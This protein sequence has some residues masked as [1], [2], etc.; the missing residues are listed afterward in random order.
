MVIERERTAITPMTAV[1]LL[2]DLVSIPSVSGDEAC[3]VSWLCEV[4]ESLGYDATIDGAGNAVGTT[5]QGEREILLLGHI[6][7]VRGEIPVRIEDG[8]LHGRGAVDAKGPLAA[9]VVAGANAKLPEGVRL[10][11]VGAVGEETLGSPGATWLAQHRQA[12]EAVVIGEPS[13]WDGLVLG[14]KG[15]LGL[16]ATVT[17]DMSHSAGPAPTAPELVFRFWLTL[18]SWLAEHNDDAPAGFDTLDATLRAMHSGGDGLIDRATLVITFRLP[19]GTEST[20]VRE[21]VSTLAQ[22]AGIDL[23]WRHNAEGFRTDKRSPLVAPFL[24]AIRAN[25]GTPRLKVKTGTS[26]MNIVGPAWNCPIAAY[27]PG[28]AHFDHTPDEQINL[29]EYQRSI[30]VL[31]SAIETMS[32]RFEGRGRG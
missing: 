30:D 3:A 22:T 17:C 16:T 27:G 31:V 28:D 15:S 21:Q 19:P 10:T 23:A 12:P 6:D 25:G 13:G 2:H 29:A 1:D 32:R 7:T 4:M 11:V 24:A 14:Y 5:G 18:Q 20:W 8:V 26:D 9:F